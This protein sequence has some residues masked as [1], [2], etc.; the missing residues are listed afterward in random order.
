MWRLLFTLAITVRGATTFA[1]LRPILE[2][3]CVA[4]HNPQ[5]IAPMSFTSYRQVR[6]W[7]KAIAAAVSQG[8]MPPWFADPRF[9]AFTNDPRLTDVE[10]S[11]VEQWI[12]DGATEGKRL[13]EIQ[14]RESRNRADLVL[15]SPPAIAVPAKGRDRKSTRLNS[16]HSQQSRMPSS[17]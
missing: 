11:V 17:A 9:G 7:A 5:G 15:K 4:C 16:S 12:N 8:K 13:P 14:A 10:R 1:D 6:P 2:K 3:H